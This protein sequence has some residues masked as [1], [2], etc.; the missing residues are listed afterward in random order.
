MS[1]AIPFSPPPT[2]EQVAAYNN[3]VLFAVAQ[4]VMTTTRY[5]DG[6][7]VSH[8]EFWLIGPRYSDGIYQDSFPLGHGFSFRTAEE[9]GFD[10][11]E[12]LLF[13]AY[14]DLQ[15]NVHGRPAQAMSVL[16][17]IIERCSRVT[18]AIAGQIA[19]WYR[20]R[21]LLSTLGR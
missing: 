2:A 20:R 1:A 17:P 7:V 14:R 4:T 6:R 13:C 19:A 18:D 9:L 11:A 21:H 10:N 5:N 8:P 3:T 15:R 16:R 12:L